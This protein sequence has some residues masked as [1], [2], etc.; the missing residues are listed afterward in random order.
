MNFSRIQ[1]HVC[2][3]SILFIAQFSPQSTF[4]L[5]TEVL[6]AGNERTTAIISKPEGLKVFR[7]QNNGNHAVM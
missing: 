3:G 5:K 6:Y 4:L 1:S 7:W 2:V